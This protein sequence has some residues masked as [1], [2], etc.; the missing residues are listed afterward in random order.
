[1]R[2]HEF[3]EKFI[4]KNTIVRLWKP[5]IKEKPY[6]GHKMLTKEKGVMEW[7]ILDIP[8]LNDILVIHITD[9]VCTKNGEAVN[10]VIDT[11]Y[12][13]DDMIQMFEERD[14]QRC[15]NKMCMCEG[16]I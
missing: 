9:I 2:L 6:M 12:D 7:E 5:E 3:I 11:D 10:I 16:K 8:E 4:A 1:M 15:K 14:K 13:R